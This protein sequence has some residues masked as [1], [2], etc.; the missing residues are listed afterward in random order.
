MSE[1]WDALKKGAGCPFDG[2]RAESNEH[3]DK[4]VSLSVSTLYL[5]RIQTYR[6]YSVLV[7]D[8]RHVTALT[9]LNARERI[10]L[11]SDLCLA[12]EG[13][14][15]VLKPDHFNI[16]SLGNQVPHLHWHIIPR[17]KNDPRWGLPIWMTAEAD[18]PR[19]SLPA[20]DRAALL[21]DL[22]KALAV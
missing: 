8:P 11:M 2:E 12:Q 18:L 13:M 5:H 22:K 19:A 15:R 16:E 4:I 6:G 20:A 1:N 17:Y 7:F 14:H 9:D 10:A 21:E 3:W